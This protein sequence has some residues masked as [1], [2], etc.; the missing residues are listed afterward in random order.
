MDQKNN[1]MPSDH[2]KDSIEKQYGTWCCS[3]KQDKKNNR[4]SDD[5]IS[6]LNEIEL[7]CWE[8][9][10]TFYKLYENIKLWIETNNKMPSQSSN[11]KLERQ[12]GK[13]CSRKRQDYKKGKLSNDK[14]LK[15][16][17]LKNW[18]WV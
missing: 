3:R 11:N 7:W 17:K 10:D 6:K 2:S 18:Y 4:L 16:Q 15:L 9:E 1:K 14:V 13:W 5:K 12:Y 8:K